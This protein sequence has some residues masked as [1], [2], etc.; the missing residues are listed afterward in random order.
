MPYLTLLNL[1]D[2]LVYLILLFCLLIFAFGFL[3]GILVILGFLV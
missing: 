1:C 3:I 2:V